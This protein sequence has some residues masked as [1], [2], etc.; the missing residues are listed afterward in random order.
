MHLDWTRILNEIYTRRDK[1]SV[2]EYAL[3]YLAYAVKEDQENR[4]APVRE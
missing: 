2:G 3:A 4:G 1:R